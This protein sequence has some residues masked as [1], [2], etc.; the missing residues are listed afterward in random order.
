M[1][2]NKGFSSTSSKYWIKKV[3]N[4]ENYSL[5]SMYLQ[6]QPDLFPFLFPPTLISISTRY[7]HVRVN[8]YIESNTRCYLLE[9]LKFDNY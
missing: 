4:G 6:T 3:K 2:C 9:A 5:T 8:V 7:I 1:R